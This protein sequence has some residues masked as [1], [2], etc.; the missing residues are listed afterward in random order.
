MFDDVSVFVSVRKMP[1]RSSK[2]I[3]RTTGQQKSNHLS[4]STLTTAESVTVE[5]ATSDTEDEQQFK[6]P[7]VSVSNDTLSCPKLTTRTT[8][9]LGH[10]CSNDTVQNVSGHAPSPHAIRGFGLLTVK[11][12]VN[13]IEGKLDA[14]TVAA[15]VAADPSHAVSSKS[16][17]TPGMA[18]LTGTVCTNYLI[19]QT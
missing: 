2:R 3:K 17:R 8:V 12:K 7:I 18:V 4:T 9:S 15:V 19:C 11:D 16:P 10:R 1:V 5:S 13:V 6:S 14:D